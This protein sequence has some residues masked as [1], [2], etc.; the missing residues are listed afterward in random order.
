[1]SPKELAELTLKEETVDDAIA[2]VD[3]LINIH[4]I[5][6]NEIFVLGHSH[7]G[8]A[9]PAIAKG[10]TKATGFIIMAGNSRPLE[11]LLIEQYTYIFNLDGSMSPEEKAALA[12]IN[13]QV[14]LLK[15][16]KVT[17]QTPGAELPLG[18]PPA[19][20]LAL[21]AYDPVSTA[22]NMKRPVLVIQGGRDYQVTV[23]D[24][25]GWRKAFKDND[26]TTFKVYPPLNHLFMAG[27]G[28]C[29]PSEYSVAGSVN[30][31]VINDIHLWIKNVHQ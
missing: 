25:D 15:S 27:E 2:A 16:G 23:K 5:N 13:R 8:M 3:L 7:G 22:R 21:N 11:D 24:V 26:R 17:L 31:E 4:Q 28:R 1:M 12:D 19:Y 6:N 20:W 29:T 14:A 18:M 30:E 9:I 10:A